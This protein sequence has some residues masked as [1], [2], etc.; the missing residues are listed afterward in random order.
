MNTPPTDTKP[1]PRPSGVRY[2]ELRTRERWGQSWT[3]TLSTIGVDGRVLSN[4]VQV[5][6]GSGF[7]DQEITFDTGWVPVKTTGVS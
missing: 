3:R 5:S 4:R 6:R 2:A 1:A 7:T